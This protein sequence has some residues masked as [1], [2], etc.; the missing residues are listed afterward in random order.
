MLPHETH[1]SCKRPHNDMT[2][3][4][5]PSFLLFGDSV[6]QCGSGWCGTCYVDQAVL[7][8]RDLPASVPKVLGLKVCATMPVISFAVFYWSSAM[9]VLG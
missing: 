2:T 1:A 7:D 3:Y 8:V 4:G 9:F 5:I 6:L